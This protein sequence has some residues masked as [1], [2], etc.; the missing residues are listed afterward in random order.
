MAVFPTTFQFTDGLYTNL[1]GSN[2]VYPQ[3]RKVRQWQLV[4]DFS[5]SR[6][7]HGL[8]SQAGSLIPGVTHSTLARTSAWS[9]SMRLAQPAFG[10][11]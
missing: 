11:S 4:D 2:N 9:R 10:T 1:G 3:G 5:V 8:P 6:G 7:A